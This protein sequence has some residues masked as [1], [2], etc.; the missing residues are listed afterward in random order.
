MRKRKKRYL[1]SPNIGEQK[2][3]NPVIL[4]VILSEESTQIDFGYAAPSIYVNG[5]WIRIAP[6]AYLQTQGS[7]NRY[8][9]KQVKNIALAPDQ[10]HFESKQDWRVFSLY[11]EPIPIQDCVIDM[12]ET[13]NPSDNDFNYY[14]IK[15]NNVKECELKEDVLEKTT[16]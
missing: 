6:E 10:L 2:K 11:F 7:N 1:I 12:I 4:R 15:L 5:G 14:G 9:L 3:K 16:S 13:E 8:S